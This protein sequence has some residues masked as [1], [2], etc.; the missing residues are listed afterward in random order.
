MLLGHAGQG[1]M[2]AVPCWQLQPTVATWPLAT[3][4][5]GGRAVRVEAVQRRHACIG[6][7]CVILSSW[8]SIL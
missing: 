7:G 1:G 3:G 5:M 4:N 8:S 2:E 6:S